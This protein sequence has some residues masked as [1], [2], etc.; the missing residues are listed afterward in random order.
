MFRTKLFELPLRIKLNLSVTRNG[1]ERQL[2]QRLR[3]NHKFEASLNYTA[4]FC[5]KIDTPTK[6]NL[7]ILKF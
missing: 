5:P 6:K 2:L 3:Q 7:A 4:R 1:L